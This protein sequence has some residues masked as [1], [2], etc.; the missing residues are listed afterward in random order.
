M[1]IVCFIEVKESRNYYLLGVL[2]SDAQSCSAKEKT[3]HS[4]RQMLYT[5]STT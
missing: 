5:V 1:S 3:R 2:G 4:M